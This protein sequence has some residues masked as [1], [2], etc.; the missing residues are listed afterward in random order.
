MD[1]ASYRIHHSPDGEIFRIKPETDDN[2]VIWVPMAARVPMILVSKEVNREFTEV[3]FQSSTRV[4]QAA[5]L[6]GY[7]TLQADVSRGYIA[8]D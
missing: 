2:Q 3:I 1:C 5:S 4:Y 8:F 7:T 6:L